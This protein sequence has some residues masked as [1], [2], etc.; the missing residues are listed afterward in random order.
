MDNNNVTN[1]L[2]GLVKYAESFLAKA[3]TAE[4]LNIPEDQKE[5][6]KEEMEKRGVPEQL[7]K[8]KEALNGLRNITNTINGA[9]H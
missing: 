1:D 2:A 3:Q 9:A 7:E 8:L 6:F 4:G 5:K